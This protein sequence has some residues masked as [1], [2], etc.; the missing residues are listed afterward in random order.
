VCYSSVLT[1]GGKTIVRHKT[2]V[3][4]SVFCAAIPALLVPQKSPSQSSDPPPPPSLKTV[5]VPEPPNLSDFVRDRQ[6]AIALGKA[7]FWD[8]QVGSDGIVACATCHF[9]AGADS[10][11]VNQL[12]PGSNR[13]TN[14]TYTPDP[15]R[16]INKGANAQLTAADFPFH[17]LADPTTRTSPVLSDTNDVASSQ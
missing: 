1:V 5:P 15:D 3:V 12:N 2:A 7:L 16:T 11:S 9:H 17:K 4:I 14:L 13:V 10:R 8:M 6:L